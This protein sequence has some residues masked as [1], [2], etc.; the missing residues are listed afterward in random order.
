M[1]KEEIINQNAGLIYDISKK[2]YGYPKEDLLQAGVL[3]LLQAYKQYDE[4]FN[5]KFTRF[6]YNYI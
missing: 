1:T 6:A 4:S 5:A 2:F 3:G